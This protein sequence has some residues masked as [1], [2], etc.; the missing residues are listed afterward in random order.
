[1]TTALTV[2]IGG[3]VL[4]HLRYNGNATIPLILEFK[5]HLKSHLKSSFP[6]QKNRSTLFFNTFCQCLIRSSSIFLALTKTCK[7]LF[8]N[9][10]M[11]P[12][13]VQSTFEYWSDIGLIFCG[14]EFHI[15]FQSFLLDFVTHILFFP[16]A[17][18]V[19]ATAVN[20]YAY[21]SFT[22]IKEKCTVF[23][24]RTQIKPY[25]YMLLNIQNPELKQNLDFPCSVSIHLRDNFKL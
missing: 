24:W 23:S 6:P 10:I 18:Y 11:T 17:P 15:A 16:R 21:S 19:G 4:P 3:F 1:M 7:K 2:V 5:S 9:G 14:K 13:N 22:L 25:I 8:F 20:L 12:A